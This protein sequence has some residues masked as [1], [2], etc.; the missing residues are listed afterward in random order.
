[1]TIAT[2]FLS[3][4]LSWVVASVA[5]AEGVFALQMTAKR[6]KQEPAITGST[7]QELEGTQWVLRSWSDKEPAPQTP[8]VTLTY[9]EGQFAGRGGC[10]NY[11]ASVKPGNPQGE[12]SVGPAGATRMACPDPAGAIETRFLGQLAAVQKFAIVAGQLSL[13]FTTKD[14]VTKAMLFDRK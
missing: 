14:G 10:N 4:A 13:T 1:M 9:K 6:E 2:M 3:M 12:I 5:L 8:E 11:F 7:L